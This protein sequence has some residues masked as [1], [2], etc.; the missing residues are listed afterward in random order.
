MTCN[1]LSGM[2]NLYTTTTWRSTGLIC[3]S[4]PWM[5]TA[6]VIIIYILPGKNWEIGTLAIAVNPLYNTQLCMCS[7]QSWQRAWLVA[8]I[9]L[10]VLRLYC[11]CLC[12]F[13]LVASCCKWLW[14]NVKS[15]Y[16]CTSN[17]CYCID[18]IG[19]RDNLKVVHQTTDITVTVILPEWI[20]I[21][22]FSLPSS[23][24][25]FLPLSSLS[26][27]INNNN[28]SFISQL[29]VCNC[30]TTSC[31]TGQHSTVEHKEPVIIQPNVTY[32]V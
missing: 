28:C 8:A 19:S 16:N 29:I 25:P 12:L 7:C 32:M 10:M 21:L 31:Q 24:I 15:V 9:F 13:Y 2:L 30:F 5:R 22:S 27:N 3:Y 26:S 1:V 4:I 20:A 17:E 18:H 14:L 23:P 11:V 6:N